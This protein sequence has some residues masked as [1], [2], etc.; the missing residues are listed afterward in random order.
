MCSKRFCLI[1]TIML[2]AAACGDDTPANSNGTDAAVEDIAGEVAEDM[3]DDCTEDP[4]GDAVDETD[5]GDEPD[6]PLQDLMGDDPVLD[7]ADQQPDTADADL[8]SD[9]VD[10]P[11]CPRLWNVNVQPGADATA[12]ITGGDLIV[13]ATDMGPGSAIEITQSGLTGD[14]D[15]TFTFNSWVAG[16]TNAF[17][18]VGVVPEPAAPPKKAHGAIGT[19]PLVGIS[20]LINEGS[21]DAVDI[22]ATTGTAGTFRFQRTSDVLT[23]TVTVGETTATQTGALAGPLRIGAQLGAR[24]TAIVAE[25]SVHISDFA[26]MDGGSTVQSDSFDCDS[27]HP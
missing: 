18:Q 27:L 22:H 20:A 3:I 8:D 14:F 23:V 24:P 25:T 26:L 19:F 1:A 2:L 10:E 15:A 6:T 11:V 13:T 12:D 17:L 21:Q 7:L 4:I 5:V 9:I 16:A